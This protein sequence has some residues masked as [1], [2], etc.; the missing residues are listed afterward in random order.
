MI[1]PESVNVTVDVSTGIDICVGVIT[2]EGLPLPLFIA[3]IISV[4]LVGFFVVNVSIY[5]ISGSR[6]YFDWRM[7]LFQ[8]DVS[9]DD[10]T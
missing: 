4:S 6:I 9:M 2:V 5:T 8:I 7:Y 10:K 1:V 3:F